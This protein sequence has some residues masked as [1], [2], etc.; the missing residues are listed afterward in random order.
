MV[1][2]SCFPAHV[3]LGDCKASLVSRSS[4]CLKRSLP[5]LVTG[6]PLSASPTAALAAAAHQQQQHSRPRAAQSP[7]GSRKAVERCGQNFHVEHGLY[8]CEGHLPVWLQHCL[9]I[10]HGGAVSVH[11][12]DSC[13]AVA[14]AFEPLTRPPISCWAAAAA[15]CCC[16][17]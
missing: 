1:C 11:T 8:R 6:P 10:W 12:C 4:K 17:S 15:S 13:R 2:L 3:E 14:A 9:S 5:N 16:A 7:P